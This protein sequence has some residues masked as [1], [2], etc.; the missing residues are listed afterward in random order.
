MNREPTNER[1]PTDDELISEAVVRAEL[2]DT[3]IGDATARTIASQWHGGQ[4]SELYS[5]ASTGRVSEGVRDEAR[6]ALRQA[7][8]SVKENEDQ[9]AHLLALAKYLTATQDRDAV[10]GWSNLWVG[11]VE[12]EDTGLDENDECTE[13][14]SHFS[15]PHDPTCSRSPE[16]SS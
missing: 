4:A 12:Y 13:C 8:A 11:Q 6:A 7:V 2:N 16:D 3:T 14:G 1:K 5:F 9:A 10:D 15:E